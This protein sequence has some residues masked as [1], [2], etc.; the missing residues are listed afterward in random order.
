[1]S[2][3]NRYTP[4]YHQEDAYPIAAGGGRLIRERTVYSLEALDA[5]V[6]PPEDEVNQAPSY[7]QMMHCSHCFKPRSEVEKLMKCSRCK[8][9]TYCSKQCQRAD[10]SLHKEKCDRIANMD[11][12]TAKRQH[13]LQLY[14]DRH[15]RTVSMTGPSAMEL[16]DYPNLAN[17]LIMVVRLDW[18]RKKR[19]EAA[20]S[21]TQIHW[22]DPVDI[23][24]LVVTPSEARILPVLLA[25]ER[26][27]AQ[28]S[29]KA[30]VFIAMFWCPELGMTETEL[31]AYDHIEPA[32]M[33]FYQGLVDWG[34]FIKEAINSGRVF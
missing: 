2:V 21:V 16:Y 30:G 11:E 12:A 8:V 4:I 19:R 14:K 5:L 17:R 22:I 23:G 6:S 15:L 7:K 25:H 34:E 28:A 9:D 24:G 31:I 3:V 10:W 29:G 27:H 18:H 1:M 26:E 20:F 33:S 13:L 32:V